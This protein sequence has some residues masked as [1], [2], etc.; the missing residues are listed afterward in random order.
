MLVDTKVSD[1][2]TIPLVGPAAKFSRT[3][4]TIRHAA[5]ELG[6]QNNN[7]M[8]SLGFSNADIQALRDAGVISS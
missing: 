2:K 7:I 3:P 4:T 5:P 6:Q 8:L 1:G